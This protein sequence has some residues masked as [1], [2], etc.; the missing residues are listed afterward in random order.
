M[1]RPE[2]F[3]IERA[4]EDK[5]PVN[6]RGPLGIS[7]KAEQ[8]FNR[9]SLG[10]KK[11]RH[12]EKENR[13]RVRVKSALL[14]GPTLV[15]PR[16]SA[17]QRGRRQRELAKQI[18]GL[19]ETKSPENVRSR[20]QTLRRRVEEAERRLE[21]DAVCDPTEALDQVLDK[22]FEINNPRRENRY[23]PSRREQMLGSEEYHRLLSVAKQSE[24]EHRECE[25]QHS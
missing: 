2:P 10:Q 5:P 23:R 19:L 20:A 22:E 24:R 1:M 21:F 14:D 18:Q 15:N 8:E 7:E 3:Q 17:A 4:F 12:R 13:K 6:F 9:R 16:R 11:R 25:A